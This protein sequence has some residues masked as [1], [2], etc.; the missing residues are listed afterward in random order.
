MPSTVV[1]ST[2]LQAS[3]VCN[4]PWLD[5]G[6][7]VIMTKEQ[8]RSRRGGYVM[9]DTLSSASTD[10]LDVLNPGWASIMQT[11]QASPFPYAT[12]AELQL[13]GESATFTEALI[14]QGQQHTTSHLG[15][16]EESSLLQAF[17]DGGLIGAK[18][19]GLNSGSRSYLYP[20]AGSLVLGGYDESSLDGPFYN[21]S[22]ASPDKLKDRRCPLQVTITNIQLHVW[23][24]TGGLSNNKS[25]F[26]VADGPPT[27]IEPYDNL[28]RLPQDT[29]NDITVM[30]SEST[31]HTHPVSPSQYK[32]LYNLEPGMVFPASAGNITMALDITLDN[33]FR[34]TIP[35]HELVRPLRGLD[36][37]G[38]PIVDSNF[39]EVQIF[40]QAA[41]V[42]APV[43]GKA[44]LSQVW[45][46]VSH[47]TQRTPN[48]DAKSNLGLPL[49]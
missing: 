23:N 34:I 31:N 25:F 32:N 13:R 42:N 38:V 39:N 19:W 6:D 10:G 48:T 26:T 41:P 30:L 29:L 12:N 33:D 24:E 44:F 28:F 1:N 35:S 22:V 14:T 37:S 27:C 49:C 20:R 5:V 8:C 15:L 46:D 16:A 9:R 36:E 43:L 18:A 2:F 40:A 47:I 17:K 11:D 45:R 7:G 3:D 21:Y 4:P